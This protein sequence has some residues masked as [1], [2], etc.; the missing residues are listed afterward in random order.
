MISFLTHVAA[1][2]AGGCIGGVAMA[3]VA[4]RVASELDDALDAL[5]GSAN[6]L[7]HHVRDNHP[8]LARARAILDAFNSE[9]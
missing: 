5:K 1:F 9:K 6:V 8:V 4:F 7:A 2:V 3:I